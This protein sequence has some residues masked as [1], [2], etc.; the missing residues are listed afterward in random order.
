MSGLSRISGRSSYSLRSFVF[1]IISSCSYITPTTAGVDRTST[2]STAATT[3]TER[4]SA[5]QASPDRKLSSTLTSEKE[6]VS[7]FKLDNRYAC[8]KI[9]Y[10]LN[11]MSGRLLAFIEARGPKG[12][13]AD[14][15]GTGDCMD[16]DATD[17]V[18]RYDYFFCE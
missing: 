16:W 11:L 7:V 1:L 2:S 17:V 18:M 4:I 6:K 15:S 9:P 8:Y 5:T 13:V 10:L 14:G 3:S 12:T